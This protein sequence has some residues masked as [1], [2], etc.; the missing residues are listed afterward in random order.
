VGRAYKE[1]TGHGQEEKSR[2]SVR[3]TAPSVKFKLARAKPLSG[4]GDDVRS[5]GG[6]TRDH[7]VRRLTFDMRGAQKAQPFGHPLDGRVRRH[8]Y[9]RAFTMEFGDTL[10]WLRVLVAEIHCGVTSKN[11]R[12]SV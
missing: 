2:L 7:E 4:F 10:P 5:A 11:T 9:E 3:Q 12:T 8:S 6:A 1:R